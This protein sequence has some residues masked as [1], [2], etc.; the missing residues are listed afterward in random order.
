MTTNL[1]RHDN[2]WIAIILVG[3]QVLFWLIVKVFWDA[4]VRRLEK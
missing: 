4:A 3:C 2:L 1:T